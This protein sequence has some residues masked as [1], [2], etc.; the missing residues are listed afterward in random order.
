MLWRE[1]TGYE[2]AYDA[3]HWIVCVCRHMQTA[4]DARHAG[5]SFSY[6]PGPSARVALARAAPARGPPARAAPIGAA[7]AGAAFKLISLLPLLPGAPP[8]SAATAW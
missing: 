3:G 8:A 7:P 4:Y 2:T 6:I 1:K 5:D